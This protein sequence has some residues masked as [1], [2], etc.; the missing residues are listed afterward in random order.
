[1]ATRVESSSEIEEKFNA[2][3]QDIRSAGSPPTR[4][5]SRWRIWRSGRTGADAEPGDEGGDEGR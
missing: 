4:R 1:M 3:I 2:Y 5:P